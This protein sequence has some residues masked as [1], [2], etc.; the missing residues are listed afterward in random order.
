[1]KFSRPMWLGVNFGTASGL[2]SGP[3]I[4]LI[5]AGSANLDMPVLDLIAALL[6]VALVTLIYTFF[7]SLLIGLPVVYLL[8]KAEILNVF[9]L[10][11]AGFVSGAA[12]AFS[13]LLVRFD[14]ESLAYISCASGLAGFLF[15]FGYNSTDVAKD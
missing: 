1:M 12:L 9:S 5:D 13:E 8:R 15:W 14:W 3:A 2:I 4:F 6:M 7:G 10:S 11:M